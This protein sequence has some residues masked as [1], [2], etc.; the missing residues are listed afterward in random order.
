MSSA[1]SVCDTGSIFRVLNPAYIYYFFTSETSNGW[2]MLGGTLLSITGTEAL[3][4]DLG[5]FSQMGI[6]IS[7]TAYVYPCLVIYYL[8]QAAWLTG[9]YGMT[10][11]VTGNDISN[12]QGY[13]NVF[14]CACMNL[15]VT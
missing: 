2:L 12:A 1:D 10:D 4:A 5:H 11:P 9:N 3:F 6:I 15:R 7:F 13:A 8:G 14:W